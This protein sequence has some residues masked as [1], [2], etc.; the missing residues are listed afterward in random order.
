M[1]GSSAKSLALPRHWTFSIAVF[2][3][4][5]VY[6]LAF[7]WRD[8]SLM[9]SACAAVTWLGAGAACTFDPYELCVPADSSAVVLKRSWPWT[10][11]SVPMSDIVSIGSNTSFGSTPYCYLEFGLA[12]GR[13]IVICR[14][15]VRNPRVEDPRVSRLRTQISQLTG[16]RDAGFQAET[17]FIW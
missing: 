2:F 12:D 15:S 1:M 5:S 14:H 9:A 8:D 16:I 4:G 11:R 10:S 6:A 7:Y 3:I 17:T 13:P